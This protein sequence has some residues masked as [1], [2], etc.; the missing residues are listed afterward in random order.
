MNLCEGVTQMHDNISV[1]EVL[2]NHT[3]RCFKNICREKQAY[4]ILLPTVLLHLKVIVHFVVS[5]DWLKIT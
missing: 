3:D 5:Q 4:S 1:E 2:R